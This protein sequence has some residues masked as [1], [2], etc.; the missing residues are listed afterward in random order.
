M[1]P[2]LKKNVTEKEVWKQILFVCVFLS[3]YLFSAPLFEGDLDFRLNILYPG[4]GAQD[5]WL[6][7]RILLRFNHINA[8]LLLSFCWSLWY[9]HMGPWCSIGFKNKLDSFQVMVCWSLLIYASL[10]HGWEGVRA[11]KLSLNVLSPCLSPLQKFQ[12]CWSTHAWAQEHWEL[13]EELWS[14]CHCMVRPN[15]HGN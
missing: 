1:L 7:M 9:C 6:Q 12:L 13:M 15:L 2:C 8:H 5:A 14:C 10:R 11:V 4:A 3:K